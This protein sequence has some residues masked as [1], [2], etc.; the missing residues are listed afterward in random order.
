MRGG[1]IFR[2]PALGRLTDQDVARLAG[3]GL[4][5]IIDLRHPIEI[6]LEPPD[7]LPPGVPVTHAP[8]FDPDDERFTFVAAIMAGGQS[9]AAPAAPDPVGEMLAVYRWFVTSPSARAGFAEAVRHIAAA[10]GRPVLYH[11]SAGKDRTGWLSA[12]VLHVLGVDQDT[13]MADY[14]RTNSDA[15]DVIEKVAAVLA[16]QHGLDPAVVLPVLVVAPDYLD[17]AYDTAKR[18]YGSLDGYLCDGLGL[19]AAVREDL[20]GALLT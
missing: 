7:R 11:C 9:S 1:V 13:V 18:E 19:D 10:A 4:V 8:V 6:G 14:L 16:A 20:R 17:A 15:N 3:L 2:A 5:E 12:L